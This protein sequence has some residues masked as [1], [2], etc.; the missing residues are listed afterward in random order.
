MIYQAIFSAGDGKGQAIVIANNEQE[1]R[2]KLI[3][4]CEYVAGFE[5]DKIELSEILGEVIIT[6][7][8]F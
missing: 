8:G 6:D 2:Q 4:K 5:E 7:Y 1:A 3:Q